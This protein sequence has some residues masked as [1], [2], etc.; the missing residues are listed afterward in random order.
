MYGSLSI[1]RETAQDRLGPVDD[2]HVRKT[3]PTKLLPKLGRSRQSTR[4]LKEAAEQAK[5]MSRSGCVRPNERAE[6][7]AATNLEHSGYLAEEALAIREGIER[8]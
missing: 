5:C 3:C 4:H 1:R 2:S 8:V 7:K 6:R